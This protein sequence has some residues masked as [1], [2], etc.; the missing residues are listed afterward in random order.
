MNYLALLKGLVSLVS[1]VAKYFSDK[2]LI[3][4]GVAKATLEGLQDVENKMA[5]AR[6]A[7]ASVDSLPIDKDPANR[8]N[9]R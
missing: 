7:V 9:K 8:A 4:A 1:C 2:Q 5:I 6:D 3:D